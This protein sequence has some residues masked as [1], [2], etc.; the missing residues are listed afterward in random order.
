MINLLQ[1]IFKNLQDKKQ[2]ASYYFKDKKQGTNIKYA[3]KV[4]E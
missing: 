2:K 3:S 1:F 4:V